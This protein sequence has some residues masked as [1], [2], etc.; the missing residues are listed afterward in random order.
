MGVNF[1][2]AFN[3]ARA[4]MGFPENTYF[5][6]PHIFWHRV[7]LPDTAGAS[8]GEL[9]FFNANKSRG[10]TNLTTAGRLGTNNLF[11]LQKIGVIIQQG[12]DIDKNAEATQANYTE[13]A[14]LATDSAGEVSESIRKLYDNGVVNMR[15]GNRVVCDDIYGVHNFPWG[16]DARYVAGHT[17]DD[18]TLAVASQVMQVRTGAGSTQDGY[19]FENPV[20]I[21][22]DRNFDLTIDWSLHSI[23][24]YADLVVMVG[25]FGM[26]MTVTGL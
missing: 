19:W 3:R 4:G 16:A 7:A 2:Q 14:T 15:V 18:A 5:A 13:A 22:P 9:T 21:Y 8:P 23:D 11:S 26:L 25:L 10:I 17:M 12:F 24:T 1:G 20:A 6:R